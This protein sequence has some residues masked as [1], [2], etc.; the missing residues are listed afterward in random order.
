MTKMKD[1][2]PKTELPPGKARWYLV[3]ADD[4]LRLGK[5][6]RIAR[7]ATTPLLPDCRQPCP[8]RVRLLRPL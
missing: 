8:L 7:T 5:K 6:L 2:P 1:K 4:N 3:P